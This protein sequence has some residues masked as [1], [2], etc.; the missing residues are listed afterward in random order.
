[1]LV[2]IRKRNE[3]ITFMVDGTTFEIRVTRT[4]QYRVHLAIDAPQNVVAVRSELL[5]RKQSGQDA[6]RSD[7]TPTQER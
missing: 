2:L 4:G 3:S 5:T 1:M 6:G 7:A